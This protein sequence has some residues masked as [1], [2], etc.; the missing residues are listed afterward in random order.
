MASYK[1]SFT[2]NQGQH[3][4]CLCDV[5]ASLWL[6]GKES[7]CSVVTAGDMGSILE[8]GRSSGGGHGNPIQYSCPE[9]PMELVGYSP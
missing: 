8:L 9:D 1:S 7:A 2:D 5:R 4:D 6:S 3:V